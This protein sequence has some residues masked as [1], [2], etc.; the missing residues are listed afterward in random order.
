MARRQSGNVAHRAGGN[1]ASAA[2]AQSSMLNAWPPKQ[3][4]LWY[5]RTMRSRSLPAPSRVDT[6]REESGAA[7]TGIPASLAGVH[8]RALYQPVPPVGCDDDG[9]PC[10]DNKPVESTVHDELCAYAKAALRVRYAARREVLVASN[11]GVFFERGNRRALVCPDMFVSFAA[12]RG[13][14]S[15][16][17]V[18]E[19][20]GV[21]EF[22]LELLSANTWRR[23]VEVKPP[24]YEA[25][26][27]R[28]FWIFDPLGRLSDPMI[29]RCLD[30]SGTYRP[31]SA[32]RGGGWR[33][34]VLGLDLVLHAGGFRFRDPATGEILPDVVEAAA[35][36]DEAAAQRDKEAAARQAAEARVAELE[37]LLG[38]S[39]E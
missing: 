24:L 8:A 7:R 31:V 29:G 5:F 25:L 2:T 4:H 1:L 19:E 33:S 21:P 6:R 39:L 11:L 18:W 27:V 13:D 38:Q 22:V 14:R 16:Y 37:A 34:N 12:G 3:G 17:K 23:D 10:E 26:G 28:E 35:Q 20:V 32:A 36:R 15:S 30:A 9:Y